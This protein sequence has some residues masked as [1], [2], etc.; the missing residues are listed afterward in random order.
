MKRLISVLLA[1][2]LSA[3]L[4]C[5]C[6]GGQKRLSLNNLNL[7]NQFTPDINGKNSLNKDRAENGEEMTAIEK[8]Y[9]SF[10]N[11]LANFPVNFIYDNSYYS[12]FSARYFK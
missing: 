6:L 7:Q 12:G 2:L 3:T 1:C 10:I 9:N 4:F 5:S 8:E 11:N